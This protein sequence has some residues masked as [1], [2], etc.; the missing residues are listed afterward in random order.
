M[1]EPGY[2]QL[3]GAEYDKRWRAF[4]N[5]VAKAKTHG[6]IPQRRRDEF[7]C[8]RCGLSA[9]GDDYDGAGRRASLKPERRRKEMKRRVGDA[10][11]TLPQR[12][13]PP[14]PQ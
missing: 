7:I 11:E 8:A 14:L 12:P 1:Y 13:S 2:S 6:E 9:V 3:L 4:L 5:G 10:W